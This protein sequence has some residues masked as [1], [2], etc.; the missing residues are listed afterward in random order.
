M[1]HS[2]QRTSSTISVVC[3]AKTE[4]QDGDFFTAKMHR[5]EK[6]TFLDDFSRARGMLYWTYCARAVTEKG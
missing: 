2:H 5:T 4:P 1:A 6:S 3:L